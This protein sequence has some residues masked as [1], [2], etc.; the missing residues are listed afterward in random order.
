MMRE[1]RDKL[2]YDHHPF[3]NFGEVEKFEMLKNDIF[4]LIS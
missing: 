3:D 1:F 4:I 2:E